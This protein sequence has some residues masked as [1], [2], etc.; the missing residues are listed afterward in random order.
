VTPALRSLGNIVSG[1]DKQTEIVLENGALDAML[2]LLQQY[3]KQNVRKECCWALSNVAGGTA[4][5]VQW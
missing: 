5:Q 2:P 4:A 3:H 1:N